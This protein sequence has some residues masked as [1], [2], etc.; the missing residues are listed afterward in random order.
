MCDAGVPAG[1]SALLL[2]DLS[3]T[4]L[5]HADHPRTMYS[6]LPVLVC[7]LFLACGLYVIVDRGRNRVTQAFLLLCVTTAIWQG[8]W[9]VLFQVDDPHT[10]QVLV[11]VGYL[12]ILFLPTTLY[13]FLVEISDAPDERRNVAA[14]YLVACVLALVL[15]FSD[16]FV[17]GYYHYPWGYY[18]KAGQLHWIHILQTSVVVLRG[19]YVT[20]RQQAGAPP[21]QAARLRL[22]IASMLVYF[23]AATDYLCNY[24]FDF[25]PIG[26]VF[27][28]ASLAI[29]VVAIIKYDLMNSNVVV[30]TVAHEVRTPLAT[31]QLHAAAVQH[32]WP[33]LI[34]GYKLA[35][36]HG[37]CAPGSLGKMEDLEDLPRKISREVDRS[38]KIVDMM[39]VSAQLNRIDKSEFLPTTIHGCIREALDTYPFRAGERERVHWDHAE[40]FIFHGSHTLMVNVLSNLLKNALHAIKLAGHGEVTIKVGWQGRHPCLY[41]VDTGPG[42]SKSLQRTLFHPFATSKKGSTGGL[43]LAFSRNV[44]GAFG[45]RIHCDSRPGRT[46]FCLVFPPVQPASRVAA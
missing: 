31:I 36:E 10:A 45:G 4:L 40:D 35:V 38:N 7:A 34:A 15:A 16:L 26:V 21:L 44:M 9:A 42:V 41:V 30:A 24:G 17:A 19:L 32:R 18:P 5:Y 29:V 6:V 23:F 28:T 11:R 22:C 8:T 37:L 2:A 43:G 20:V 3:P 27:N 14:S 33:E 13:Q 46:T 25:Y 1:W 39:L 12:F